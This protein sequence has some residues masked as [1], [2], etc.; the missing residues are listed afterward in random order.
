M[1][2]PSVLSDLLTKDDF[3]EGVIEKQSPSFHKMWQKRYFVLK[4]RML[5][6]YKSKAD[7]DQQKTCKGVINFQQIGVDA[8]HNA[9]ELKIRLTL[10]G[11]RR[12]FDLKF[13]NHDDFAYWKV[14]LTHSIDRSMGKLKGLSLSDYTD[15][16]N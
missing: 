11:S 15:D 8:T 14:K 10:H 2:R 6:Y 1:S 5:F 12:S 13:P 7:Y 3:C 4:N 9:N 16:V